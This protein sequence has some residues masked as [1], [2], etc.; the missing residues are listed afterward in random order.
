MIGS[1]CKLDGKINRTDWLTIKFPFQL[2]YFSTKGRTLLY[3]GALG[4]K[5]SLVRIT[6]KLAASSLDIYPPAESN[7][8]GY[9]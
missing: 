9:S 8:T 1:S 6:G 3:E 4:V 7:R 5:G 2:F